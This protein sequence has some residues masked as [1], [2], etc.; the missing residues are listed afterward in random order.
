MDHRAAPPPTD[1]WPTEAVVR[2]RGVGLDRGGRAVLDGIDWEVQ[3]DQRWVVLGRNGSGKTTLARVATLHEHPSRGTV[4]VLGERLGRCDV[5]TLR[6]RIGFVSA[7]F[8]DL[9]RPHLTALEV[10]VCALHGALEP[11]WNTY[12][13]ADRDRARHHLDRVGVGGL[14]ERAVG[15]L[16]SGE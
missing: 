10:V 5:R 1:R 14:A 8:A 15:T 6:R 12:T 2:L 11:W 9:L 7:A 13:A 3:R 4:D 16:S